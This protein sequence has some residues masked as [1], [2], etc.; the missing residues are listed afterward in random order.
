[1]NSTQ[2]HNPDISYLAREFIPKGAN[3]AYIRRNSF[4]NVAAASATA[5]HAAISTAAAI[6]TG[7]TNPDFPRN[8]TITGAGSSHSAAGAVTITGTNIRDE[9]ITEAITLNSN[10]TVAGN[11]AFKTVT[12]IDTSAATGITANDTIEVGT[13]TKL[14]LDRKCDSNGVFLATVAGAADSALPTVAFSST[15]IES[16]TVIPATAANG[17]NDYIFTFVTT[18]ARTGI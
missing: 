10:T 2:V 9:V 5:I 6:T 3:T 15:A 13:G 8:V 18:E 4:T 11:K 16:N 17:T 14:G 1:M 12:K 7:I